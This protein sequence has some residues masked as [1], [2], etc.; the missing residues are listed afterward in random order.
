MKAGQVTLAA[1]AHFA[2]KLNASVVPSKERV[3]V[4]HEGTSGSYLL[5]KDVQFSFNRTT[6]MAIV[7]FVVGKS[8]HYRYRVVVHLPIE[9]K[10]YGTWQ[11]IEIQG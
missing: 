8:R 4:E 11:E 2:F 5:Q 10:S 9:K 3:D 1:W 6:R 7:K